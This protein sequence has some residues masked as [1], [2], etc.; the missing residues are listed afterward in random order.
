MAVTMGQ[1]SRQIY[2]GKLR[3]VMVKAVFVGSF[4]QEEIK[5]PGLAIGFT[6]RQSPLSHIL[7]F[8]RVV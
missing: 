2:G 8:K 1:N 6:L 5:V 4:P 7:E 3:P